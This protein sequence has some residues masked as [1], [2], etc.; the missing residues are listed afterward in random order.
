MT[1]TNKKSANK[2]ITADI[3]C[4]ETLPSEFYREQKYFDLAK[5]RIFA[6]S[7]QFACDTEQLPAR[8]GVIPW[9]LLQGYLDEPLVFTR[10]SEDEVHCLSNVCTHRGLLLVENQCEA[11]TMRCR[12]H[13]RRFAADGTFISAPGFEGAENFPAARDNLPAVQQEQFGNS[14]FVGIDP[15]FSFA[16]LTH[17]MARRLYWLPLAQAK[18]EPDRCQDYIIDANWALYVDNYL[19]GLHVPFVHPFLA[20]V[21]DTK[22]Y[23]YEVHGF[24]NLQIGIATNPDDAF[25]IPPDAPDFGSAI[26]AYYYWLFP[27]MMFNFYPWGIS[28]NIVVPL[29]VDKSCIRF[30]TYIYDRSRMG[31]SSPEQIKQ[32]EFEDHAIVQQVQKGMKSRIYK[33]GRYAP[34]WDTNVHHFHSLLSQAL[35]D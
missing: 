5:E 11:A 12:Y 29:A 17:D 13:G 19:E 26:A 33:R 15:A 1:T 23:R 8:G 9:T 24:S 27:N 4:A 25:V 32:T 34:S 28:I 2:L 30:L 35:A 16:D 18:R 14:V 3:R 20:T 22:D 7:W 21:L 6:R 10:D 31:S